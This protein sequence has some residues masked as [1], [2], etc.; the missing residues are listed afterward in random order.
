MVVKDE[1]LLRL[2][3]TRPKIPKTTSAHVDDDLVIAEQRDI[4]RARAMTNRRFGTPER[5]AK[6]DEAQMERLAHRCRDLAKR[7]AQVK[8]TSRECFARTSELDEW[9][10][11]FFWK[12][13][14]D[15]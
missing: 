2:A 8:L 9:R 10:P 14:E 4:R 15:Q 5:S 6:R 12:I 7:A 13:F 11:P 3:G 1:R